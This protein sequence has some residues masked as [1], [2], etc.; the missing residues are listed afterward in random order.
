MS[1][2]FI[3]TPGVTGGVYIEWAI[4]WDPAS[5]VNGTSTVSGTLDPLAF[6]HILEPLPWDLSIDAEGV[7]ELEATSAGVASCGYRPLK[8]IHDDS[9]AIAGT[10]TCSGTLTNTERHITPDTVDGT[11]TVLATLQAG[12]AGEF[13]IELEGRSD[14]VGAV[15]SVWS[16]RTGDGIYQDRHLYQYVNVGVGFV[17]D[18]YTGGGGTVVSYNQPDGNPTTDWDRHLMQLVNVGVS[19]ND[20]DDVTTRTVGSIADN[21]NPVAQTFSDGHIRDDWDRHLYQ[22]LRVIEKVEDPGR[23][24]IGPSPTRPTFL[25]PAKPPV[26]RV[27]RGPEVV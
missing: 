15:Q 3:G 12:A 9:V 25:P 24:T 20:T 14:G 11:S 6:N 1:G 2:S 8:L 26:S 16:L 22:F 17:M 27:G 19:F 13:Y 21:A 7:H 10:S 23:L 18:T 4:E 5:N